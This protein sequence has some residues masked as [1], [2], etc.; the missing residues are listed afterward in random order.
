MNSSNEKMQLIDSIQ[1]LTTLAETSDQRIQKL[2]NWI[3][4]LSITFMCIIMLAAYLAFNLA[5]PPV[6]VAE[7]KTFLQNI[8]HD[9]KNLTDKELQTLKSLELKEKQKFH[10]M[11][12]SIRSN[13]NKAGRFDPAHSITVILKDMKDML[14]A[15][16]RMADNM[17][18]M[19]V[20]MQEMNVK[21][22]AM[23]AMAVD[24]HHMN[25]KMGVMSHGVDST[26]GRM[27]RLMP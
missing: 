25:G 22:S 15:V 11:I 24:M 12:E 4:R 16:P 21:M 23:P 7:P 6:A 13:M 26:M 17:D 5:Y 14:E 27:G 9:V 10:S 18:T 3:I 8:G 20:A 1:R 2:E 19:N